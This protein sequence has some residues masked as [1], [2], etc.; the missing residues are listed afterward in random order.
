[1][2]VG[3]TVLTSLST[4]YVISLLCIGM[5]RDTIDSLESANSDLIK[6]NKN[7]SKSNEELKKSI[8]IK[9]AN[10]VSLRHELEAQANFNSS[11]YFNP[12]NITEL[13]GVSYAQLSYG[14]RDTKLQAYI[15][16]FLTVERKYR[17]NAFA[18]IGIVAN[19]SAWLTSDRTLR[20]NNVTGYAVYSDDSKGATFSSIEECILKTAELLAEDYVNE[21]GRFYNGLS[22]SDI[23]LLYSS[24]DKWDDTVIQIGS[25]T[26]DRINKM[27]ENFHSR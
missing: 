20:Q 13:S 17:I 2:K 18:M 27:V 21:N 7:I 1:M 15:D 8:D 26:K 12:E 14:L 4:L 16:S 25:Q 10:I 19:E 3:K 22:I 9:N 11:V 24:D 5:Q 23:N 6:E